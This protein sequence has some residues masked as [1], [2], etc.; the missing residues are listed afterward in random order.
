[1][2]GVAHGREAVADVG[3]VLRW[4]DALGNAMAEADHQLAGRQSP[5][6]HGCRHQRQQIAIVT[7]D[8]RKEVERA[9]VAGEPFDGGRDGIGTVQQRVQG[10]VRP[11][12]AQHFQTLLA[13]AHAREPVVYQHHLRIPPCI[14]APPPPNG[15]RPG[16][17]TVSARR[18]KGEGCVPE[19]SCCRLPVP[20]P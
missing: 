2:P 1:M 11:T 18:A 10:G 6:A 13:A 7:V 5:A 17:C 8:S 19:N 16:K 20:Y 12:T 14:H 4:P 15:P 9:G 3:Y